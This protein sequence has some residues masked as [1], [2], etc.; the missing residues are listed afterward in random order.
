MPEYSL[1]CV[2]TP[3]SAWLIFA[4]FFPKF[5][6]FYSSWFDLDFF[7]FDYIFLQVRFWNLLFLLRLKKLDA[8][9]LDILKGPRTIF[10]RKGVFLKTLSNSQE[11][12]CVRVLFNEVT[13]L[14]SATLLKKETPTQGIFLWIMQN[15]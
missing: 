1:I 5:D 3:K 15:F 2:N 13:D 4:W 14:R 11:N 12:P 9:S 7:V 10:K 6:F 8:L